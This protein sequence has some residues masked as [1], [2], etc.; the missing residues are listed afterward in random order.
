EM[1][2]YWMTRARESKHPVFRIRYAGLAWELAPNVKGAQRDVEMARVLIDSTIDLS[3][4]GLG[5]ADV[6][7]IPKLGW[8]LSVA[9][10]LRDAIR[11]A[12][13]REAILAFEDR[14]A[15][16][17][18]PGLWGFSFDLLLSDRHIDP[19]RTEATPEQRQKILGDLEARLV[20]LSSVEDV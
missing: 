14:V 17:Q 18:F 12:S 1:M 20:R 3:H 9:I 10:S 7:L 4:R 11:L 8:A 16:D 19:K 2:T 15:Q 6:A 5:N 13:M